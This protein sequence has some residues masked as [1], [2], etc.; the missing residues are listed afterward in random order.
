MCEA[1]DFL[2]ACFADRG[3]PFIIVVGNC[4][5]GV[6]GTAAEYGIVPVDGGGGRFKGTDWDNGGTETRIWDADD[7]FCSEVD[8]VAMWWIDFIWLEFSWTDGNVVGSCERGR[9]PWVTFWFK[10]DVRSPLG[11]AIWFV[12]TRLGEVT[13]TG[14]EFWNKS[15]NQICIN[16]LL[17]CNSLNSKRLVVDPEQSLVD[18][19]YLKFYAVAVLEC[20]SNYFAW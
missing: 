2:S 12:E 1:S 11:L 15:L 14:L 9:R 3:E 17:V 13:A 20:I 18:W 19:S 10:T 4:L 16:I 7:P 5:I 8:G 6:L